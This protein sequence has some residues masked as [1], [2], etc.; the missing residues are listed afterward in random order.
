MSAACANCS[1]AAADRGCPDCE[2]VGYCSDECCIADWIEGHY[3]ECNPNAAGIGEAVRIG[4]AA[5]KKWIQK[6]VRHPGALTARAKRN[7]RSVREEAAHD[8][9]SNDTTVRRQGNLYFTLQ[10]VRK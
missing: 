5:P 4:R 8:R 3:K 6:A 7:K 9:A 10:K 2:A 1:S